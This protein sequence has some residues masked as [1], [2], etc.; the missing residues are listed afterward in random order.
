MKGIYEQLTSWIRDLPENLIIGQLLNRF[1][2]LT[3][4]YILQC[5]QEYAIET[6]PEPAEFTLPFIFY[7]NKFHFALLSGLHLN[8]F[9]QFVFLACTLCASPMSSFSLI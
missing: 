1:P 9:G 2:T 7:L 4:T 5:S 6:Y 8:L 3:G